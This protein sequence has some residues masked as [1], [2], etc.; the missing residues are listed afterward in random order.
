MDKVSCPQE[1]AAG[2][3]SL[4]DNDAELAPSEAFSLQE[5]RPVLGLKLFSQGKK[6]LT[7]QTIMFAIQTGFKGASFY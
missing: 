3:G 6:Y 5:M 2:A 7:T 1:W 4:L